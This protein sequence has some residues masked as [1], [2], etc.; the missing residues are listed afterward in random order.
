MLEVKIKGAIGHVEIDATFTTEAGSLT[1]LLGHSGAGKTTIINM[2]A[3]LV[4][5]R[6]G[7]IAIDSDVLFD[8]AHTIDQ[9]PNKRGVGYIFQDNLLFP[10]LTVKGN[11]CYGQNLTPTA[12]RYLDFDEIVE[13]LGLKSF[14]TRR[15][16]SLSGGEKKAC[17]N[18]KSP[19]G[20]STRT[21]DG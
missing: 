4:K 9:P 17:R 10:H 18:R 20:K 6:D 16:S 13:L 3:G 5:P 2:I 12:G 21:P 1:A 8:S 11:L 7:R 19:I 14:L 15:P